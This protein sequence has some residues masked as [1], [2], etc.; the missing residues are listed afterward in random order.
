MARVRWWGGGG[1]KELCGVP[2]GSVTA[3]CSATDTIEL[4]ESPMVQ[5]SP[6]LRWPNEGE[7]VFSGSRCPFEMARSDPH[8]DCNSSDDCVVVKDAVL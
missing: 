6:G 4:A 7:D 3:S 5:N 8:E 2:A 1:G